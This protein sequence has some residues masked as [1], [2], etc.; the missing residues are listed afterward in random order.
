MSALGRASQAHPKTVLISQSCRPK[1]S[2]STFKNLVSCLPSPSF[3]TLLLPSGRACPWIPRQNPHACTMGV[4]CSS[5]GIERIPQHNP[6]SP[7]KSA[8]FFKR[9]SS[10]LHSA[11]RNFGSLAVYRCREQRL[12]SPMGAPVSATG[13]NSP[14]VP[15][16][17]P[18]QAGRWEG[19]G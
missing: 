14:L 13:H 10:C 9:F 19:E 2:Q 5:P 3:P 8:G 16:H 6:M 15:S 7:M 18:Q 4:T 12:D 17:P 1:C 11:C